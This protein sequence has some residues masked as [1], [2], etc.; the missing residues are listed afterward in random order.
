VNS[1]KITFRIRTPLML[2]GIHKEDGVQRVKQEEKELDYSVITK[3]ANMN[4]NA[5][6]GL[7]RWWFRC[8]NG[9]SKELIKREAEIFGS[10]NNAARFKIKI[11]PE[12]NDKRIWDINGINVRDYGKYKFS[13][14]SG[15]YNGLKY[16]SYNF[17]AKSDKQQKINQSQYF[18]PGISS[19]FS[20]Q[21]IADSQDILTKVLM[22][23]WLALQF[24]GIGNRS[25]RCFGNLKI[26]SEEDISVNGET[27]RFKNTYNDID[28][29]K[30][31]I[32]KN[33][34]II[35]EQFS[36]LQD[37]PANQSSIPTLNG[38]K[39][40]LSMPVLQAEDN[41]SDFQMASLKAGRCEPN[42]EEA[43]NF[44]GVTM[45]FFR[46]LK[47][48]DYLNTHNFDSLF[49]IERA[50]FGLPLQFRFSGGNPSV[51]I[52]QFNKKDEEQRLASPIITSVTGIGDNNN[53][54]LKHFHIQYLIL[55]FNYCS[56][57]VKAVQNGTKKS[58][59]INNI[60]NDFIN[61]LKEPIEDNIAGELNKGV[62]NDFKYKEINL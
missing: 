57:N 6:K 48:A 55:K 17:Y 35:R 21:I 56:L 30:G 47:E 59:L 29:Y 13:K 43:I 19:E 49:S 25:R 20:I 41:L 28:D 10:T 15:K 2:G 11:L 12:A 33:L 37:N 51:I 3:T 9:Y 61:H 22:I 45:Q 54:K 40:F 32:A 42:W 44:A 52:N 62:I 34:K 39:L 7:L 1:K 14:G 58:V 53:K 38:A 27:F 31:T 24:A 5:F 16:F 23:L 50:V 8:I 4:A 46:A 26:I 60:V 36:S 18:E